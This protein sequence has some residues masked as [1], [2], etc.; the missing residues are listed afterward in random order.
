V[1]TQALAG[2]LWY[3]NDE[4]VAFPE[5]LLES[6]TADYPVD[7]DDCRVV[8]RDIRGVSSGWSTVVFD[9]VAR[10]LSEGLYVIF[11]FPE[12][13]EYTAIG[14]GGGAAMGYSTNGAGYTGWISADG[15]DWIAFAGAAR[16]SVE[17]V[18]VDAS[19]A[20]IVML[21]RSSREGQDGLPR[22]TELYRPTP[23]PSNPGTTI[24]FNLESQEKIELCIYNIRGIKV[25]VLVD[26]VVDR[27]GHTVFWDGRDGNGR[28]VASGV[29]V[30]RMKV[31]TA[32]MT[33][34]LL[35]LR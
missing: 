35:L 23:N 11:R 27:G 32:T 30:A 33:Q 16:F 15:E 34:K 22:R 13:S 10:S 3:N 9:E 7:L 31:P 26:E 6:G 17:P 4:T 20:T 24:E 21:G 25:R 19:E 2:I 12:G 8:A 18:Y 28:N 5:V 29:Y 1:E 14:T